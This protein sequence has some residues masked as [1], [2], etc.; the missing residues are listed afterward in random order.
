MTENT[1]ATGGALAPAGE[2]IFV[3]TGPIQFEGAEPIQWVGAGPP[4]PLEDDALDDFFQTLVVGVTGLEGKWVRPRFQTE[5]PNLPPATQ[6]WVSVGVMNRTRDTYAAV[7]HDPV[8][9]GWD[10]VS[11]GEDLELLCSFYGPNCQ[12]I[13]AMFDDGL[14]VAQNREVLFHSGMELTSTGDLQKRPELVKERWYSRADL[15]VFL[16]RQVVRY[17]PVRSLVSALITMAAPPL[18]KSVTVAP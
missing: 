17:Y 14:M 9:E 18:D 10:S 8:G 4:P 2:L 3:G 13:G 6:N 7:Q 11:R 16:R 5:P 12:G 15:S 1:S